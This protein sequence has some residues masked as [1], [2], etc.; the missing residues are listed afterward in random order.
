MDIL[1]EV[2]VTY[3]S[4]VL[5]H[6]LNYVLYPQEKKAP[7]VIKINAGPHVNLNHY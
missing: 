6:S 7:M 5:N 3:L 2:A 1:L 4:I